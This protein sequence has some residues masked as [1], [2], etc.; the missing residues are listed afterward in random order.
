MRRECHRLRHLAEYN[1]AMG[2]VAGRAD[3][4]PVPL[5]QREVVAESVA[6][7]THNRLARIATR[8]AAVAAAVAAVAAVAVAPERNDGDA[9]CD[10]TT[11]HAMAGTQSAMPPGILAA[12]VVPQDTLQATDTRHNSNRPHSTAAVLSLESAAAP[13]VMYSD[14]NLL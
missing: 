13:A 14:T 7:Q 5:L 9:V 12:A 6:M 8:I 3:K 2:R 10:G 1:L 11:V 4:L